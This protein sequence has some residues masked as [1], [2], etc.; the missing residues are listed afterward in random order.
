M[1]APGVPATVEMRAALHADLVL[2]AEDEEGV[3]PHGEAGV[4]ERA[5]PGEVS[6]HVDRCVAVDAVELEQDAAAGVFGRGDVGLAVLEHAAREV[7]VRLAPRNI[8]AARLSDER[9]VRQM[10]VSPAGCGA[11]AQLLERGDLA[12]EAPSVIEE[13]ATGR[14]PGVV[15]T[16]HLCDCNLL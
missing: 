2:G 13:D 11:S 16:L 15:T 7:P 3:D 1:P 5:L 12:A 8:G 10:H 9:V 6:V 4:A 14:R